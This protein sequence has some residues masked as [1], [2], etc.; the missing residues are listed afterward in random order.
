SAF[1]C[2]LLC[3]GLGAAPFQEWQKTGESP[4]SG[5]LFPLAVGPVSG[6]P[7]VYTVLS[8]GERLPDLPKS[9]ETPKPKHHCNTTHHSEPIHK[10]IDNSKS[11]DHK[12]PT[13][14]HEAPPTS[15]Q[16]PSNQGKEPITRNKRSVDPTNSATTHKDS[17][18]KKHL[19][20][21]PKSKTTCRRSTIKRPTRKPMVT[22]N[23]DK[24]ISSLEKTTITLRNKSTT[25]P[26]ITIPFHLSDNSGSNKKTTSSSEKITTATKT[27]YKTIQTPQKSEKPEDSTTVA[28]DKLQIKTTKHI[29]E[30][31]LATNEETT[32]SPVK[33]T[34]HGEKTTSANEETTSSPVKPT[35]HGEKTTSANEETTSSPKTTSFPVKPTQHGEKTTSANEKTTSSPVKPTQHEEKITSANEKT[36]SSPSIRPPVKVTGDKFVAATSPYLH[37]TGVTLR[38]PLVLMELSSILWLPRSLHPG[39]M[40]ENDPFPTDQNT[41]DN[42][43]EDEGGPNSYPVYMMEQQTLGRGQ[44]PSPR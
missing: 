2:V 31:T 25:S 33:P 20:P 43:P 34:Q 38:C 39:Q 28:S 35:Q 1:M 21:A 29:K 12:R 36:T 41:W 27:T 24:T 13:A 23:S 19:T 26:K 40:G 44:I 6:A 8:S 18:D 9:I 32:S 17:S 14:D 3:S 4:T 22:G 5:H 42:D 11:T 37:K 10:P 15:G 7:S 16:N 30:T